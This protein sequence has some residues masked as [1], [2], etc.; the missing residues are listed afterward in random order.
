MIALGAIVMYGWRLTWQLASVLCHDPRVCIC[1][2]TCVLCQSRG[3]TKFKLFG[4][5]SRTQ[6]GLP[7]YVIRGGGGAF[8]RPSLRCCDVD[9]PMPGAAST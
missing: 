3:H 4:V 9:G 2:Y 5:Q 6:R 1:V 7:R 8:P